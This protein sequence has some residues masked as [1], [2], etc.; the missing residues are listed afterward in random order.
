M[1]G[2]SYAYALIVEYIGTAFHGFQFQD[3]PRTVQAELE[4]ALAVFLRE[5]VRLS[6]CGRTDAGV[7]AT[8][9]VVGLRCA[10]SDLDE[11]RLVTGLN[12]LLPN[13][14]VVRR[15]SPVPDDFHPRFSCVAREYEYL[16][17][18][19]PT[20]PGLWRD[21]V[22]WLRETLPVA[23]LHAELQ[24]ILGHRDFQAF[25]RVE[26]KDETTQ[27]YVD[28]AELTLDT[29][30]PAA[31]SGPRLLRF[32]I[33]GNAFLHNMVRILVGTLMDRGAGKVSLT[34][35]E[36]LESGDRLAA[37]QTAPA[38]GL[39]FRHAYYAPVAG[40]RHLAILEGYPNF[41]TVPPPA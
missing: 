21:R 19:D 25:T 23:E 8:G 10:Q 39:Y 31:T 4:R 13:D 34:L 18:N 9:Q 20:P 5:Q 3:G 6:C 12:A 17:W 2:A 32:R 30:P 35:G 22:W 16:I 40:A 28:L 11:H 14:L 37:G 27:R 26:H 1:A 15:M 33:R 7:H 36:I 38:H 41:R 29:N 24:Q